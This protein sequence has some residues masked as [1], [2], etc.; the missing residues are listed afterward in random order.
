M[1]ITGLI[2]VIGE[3]QTVGSNNFQKRELVVTTEDRYPQD[4]LIE[5]AKDNC[6][7]LNTYKVGERV[8]VSINLR[9]REW[10]NPEG[11]ARYFNSIQGWRI[12]KAELA[13]SPKAEVEDLPF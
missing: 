9:G 12:Q 10:I 8:N 7:K 1:E 5:F 11:V 3:T 4:I 6:E 13:D 2:K